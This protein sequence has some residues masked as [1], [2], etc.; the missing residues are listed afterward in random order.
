MTDY[1]TKLTD[2]GDSLTDEEA[3]EYIK[4]KK[5][6]MQSASKITKF[7]GS[8]DNWEIQR[9]INPSA[10]YEYAYVLLDTANTADD[11]TGNNKFGW[12]VINYL[13]SQ[14]GFVSTTS[15]IRD[16]VAMRIFPVTMVLDTPIGESNKNYYNAVSNLNNMFTI[17]IHEFQAQ[18]YIGRDGRRFHFALFPALMNPTG[19]DY[20]LRPITP[21]Q[22]YYEFTTSGKANGWFWFRKPIT[23]FNTMTVSIGIPFDLISPDVNTRTLI[24]LQLIYLKSKFDK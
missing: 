10:Q 23:E 6:A 18:S 11:L 14:R 5:K 19:G 17:L 16:V 20:A 21:A 13:T 12:R 9:A 3:L 22:P 4:A 15:N 1:K 24:P 2:I 8:A 7:L